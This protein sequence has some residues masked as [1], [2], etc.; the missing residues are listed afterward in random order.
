MDKEN[1]IEKRIDSKNLPE[2]LKDI[3]FIIKKIGKINTTP[4][5]ASKSGMSFFTTGLFNKELLNG[6]NVK[7]IIASKK[8]KLKAIVVHT[9]FKYVKEIEQN[10]LRIGIKFLM[11]NALKKYHN[12]FE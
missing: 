1:R 4:T 2:Y 11:N 9:E 12:L 10:L 5:D 3:I 8:L 7:V 6:T